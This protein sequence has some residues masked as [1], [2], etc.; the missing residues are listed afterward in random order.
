MM[1]EARSTSSANVRH[2]YRVKSL[3][4]AKEKGE[5]AALEAALRAAGIDPDSI[6]GVAKR[7]ENAGSLDDKSEGEEE[8]ATKPESRGTTAL[9]NSE[10]KAQKRGVQ[11]Q[12]LPDG[13]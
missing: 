7:S 5:N 11:L 1:S 4:L 6:S 2:G 12:K 13:K 8:S 9:K 10:G 3:D